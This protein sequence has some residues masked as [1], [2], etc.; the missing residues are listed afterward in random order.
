MRTANPALNSKTFTDVA[1]VSVLSRAMTIQGTINKTF[2]MLI[3]VLIPAAWIW[4]LFNSGN[5][6]VVM[7]WLFGG[8]IGGFIV[9][10]VTIFKKQWAVVTAPLYSVLEGLAIG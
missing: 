7:P 6:Q 10:L 5:P 4:N 9:A 2:L 1:G 3:L 8:T